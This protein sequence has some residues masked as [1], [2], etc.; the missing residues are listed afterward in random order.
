MVPV[1]AM[2]NFSKAKGTWIVSS[3]AL[4]EGDPERRGLVSSFGASF[5]IL[6]E[7]TECL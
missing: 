1:I 5:V 2:M 4:V 6:I 3:F 7:R